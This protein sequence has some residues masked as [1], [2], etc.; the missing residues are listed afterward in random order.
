[1]LLF[2]RLPSG[3]DGSDRGTCRTALQNF[4][5]LLSPL[6]ITVALLTGS[7]K[8][9]EKRE[10]KAACASGEIQ[11]LI[12]THAV[13]QDDVAF[14][15]LAFIVTDEQHRFGVKQRDAFMKKERSPCSCNECD[16]DSTYTGNYFVQRFRC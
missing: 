2:L 14:D 16:A 13:I 9:K 8:A 12:G 11:I 10:I 7:T 15:N 5:K 6:G 3:V 1:M 4:V